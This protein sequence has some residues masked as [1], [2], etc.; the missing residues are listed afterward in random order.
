MIDAEFLNFDTG[1]TL[2]DK[3]M[4]DMFL[5]VLSYISENER[6][7]ILERQRQG[8]K[9]AKKKGVYKGRKVEYSSD[10]NNP[11]KRVI[12]NQI[13]HDLDQGK[14]I[15]QIARDAGVSRPTVYRIIKNINMGTNI[16]RGD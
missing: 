1:N 5:S 10:T 3:A 11:Q 6:E 12:Y 13:I 8:I 14:S 16:W 7:K 2:L 15:S 9:Q 4:F